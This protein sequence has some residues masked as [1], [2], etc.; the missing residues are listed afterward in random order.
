MRRVL[1]LILF[2]TAATLGAAIDP[3][4]PL[5]RTVKVR[6]GLPAL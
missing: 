4:A 3:P 5:V 1:M 6:P 2:G